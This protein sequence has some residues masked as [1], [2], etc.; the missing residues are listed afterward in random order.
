MEPELVETLLDRD[1][2]AF[3]AQTRRLGLGRPTRCCTRIALTVSPPGTDERFRA[4]LLCDD[5]DAVAPLLDFADLRTGKDLGRAH[6]PR[7]RDAPYNEITFGGRHVPI[8]CTPGTRGYHLHPSHHT[9]V[10]D[11]AIWTLPRQASLLGRLM[12]QMGPYCGRGM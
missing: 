8:L 4:V 7:M 2:G 11:K 1:W 5:Y 9:E 6:W 12:T 3:V 10:H